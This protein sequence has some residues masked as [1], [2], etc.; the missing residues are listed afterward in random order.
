MDSNK[1]LAR[2]KE[3]RETGT[4]MLTDYKYAI[5]I[6]DVTKDCSEKSGGRLFEQVG[7]YHQITRA[8]REYNKV[9]DEYADQVD[10]IIV[11]LVRLP[12]TH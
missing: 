10:D 7:K 4:R 12:I 3:W 1:K 5:Y 2:D 8:M 11:S 6:T 9:A